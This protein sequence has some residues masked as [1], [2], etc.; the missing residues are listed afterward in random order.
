MEVKIFVPVKIVSAYAIKCTLILLLMCGMLPVEVLGADIYTKDKSP[1]L[2]EGKTFSDLPIIIRQEIKGKVRDENGESMIGVSILEKGTG[3]GTVTDLGG[4]Y[5]LVVKDAGSVLVFSYVG[6]QR[7]EVA[8]NNQSEI[9]VS[10]T[11]DNTL[12]QVVVTALGIE[13]KKKDLGYSVS[14]VK[15]EEL[16]K[17]SE[18]NP[19]NALQG[20]VAGYRLIKEVGELLGLPKS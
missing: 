8:V 16:S 20:R 12:E 19:V 4:S 11:P 6:Y 15:G 10:L 14:E 18:L 5:T 3:N 7:V 2:L 13:R 1:F 9:N 17:T